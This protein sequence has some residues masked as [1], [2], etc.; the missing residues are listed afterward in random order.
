VLNGLTLGVQNSA[1]RHYPDVSFHGVSI[2]IP[3][4]VF[5]SGCGTVMGPVWI[6]SVIR[7]QPRVC[8]ICRY[9]SPAASG[10]STNRV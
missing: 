3:L 6:T 1:F 8:D 2:A 5:T 9:S 7:N 10:R 4:R